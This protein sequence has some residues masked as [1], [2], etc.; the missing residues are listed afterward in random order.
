MFKNSF[1][2][3]FKMDHNASNRIFGLDFLRF[4]AISMVILGHSTVVMPPEFK[5]AIQRYMLDGV[6]IFFVLSGFLIGGI[7]IRQL[8]KGKDSWSDL[9]HFWKRRWLRTIPAYFFVLTGILVY[10]LI[11]MPD[12]FPGQWYEFYIFCQNLWHPRPEFYGEAWSLSVEEWFYLIVPSLIFGG[13][14]LFRSSPKRMVLT[15]I[16]VVTAAAITYRY[17]LF[18]QLIHDESI[19][20][21]K[22]LKKLGDGLITYRILP[23]LDAL[24]FGVMGAYLM[25]YFPAIWR[26]WKLPVRF[27]LFAAGWFI[28]Y[29]VKRD[30]AVDFVLYDAVWS[31]VLKAAAVLIM[32]PFLSKLVFRPNWITRFITFISLI[33]YSMYLVNWKVVLIMI[34]KN[35]IYQQLHGPWT[36]TAH[37]ELDYCVFLGITI[38]LSYLIY[39]LIEVPFMNLRK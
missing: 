34:M 38:A 9:V 11:V 27:L 17:L 26:L 14:A 29:A 32:L 24:M 37:W 20:S 1:R 28:L 5:P 18:Q 13:I 25:H 2:E 21:F 31:H 36:V 35:G 10:T 6:S 16:I 4:V 7:L 33:S 39:R 22:E 15:V 3:L 23:R 12:R 30:N 19:S 8:E